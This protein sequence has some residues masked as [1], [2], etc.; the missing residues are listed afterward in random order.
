MPANARSVR[1]FAPAKVNLLLHVGDRRADG[2]HDLQS[3]VAFAS[4]GDEL[5]LEQS[6][7]LSLAIEGAFASSLASDETNL[8]LRAARAL[9]ATTANRGH[10]HIVL[11][12]NLPVASGIGGGS[13]D[14]AATLRGLV[15]LWQLDID[16]SAL[17]RIAED[18]GSDVPVCMSS[19]PSWMEGRGERV[20]ELPPLPALSLVL[21]NPGIAISTGAVFDALTRRRGIEGTMPT[22]FSNPDTL[23]EFLRV[24]S[25]DLE[26]AALSIAPVIGDVLKAL[27][28]TRNIELARMSGSGATCFGLFRSERDAVAAASSLR[29]A[30]R[31]WWVQEA[32]FYAIGTDQ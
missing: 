4:V 5:R 1:A 21:V 28:G 18:L 26:P 24:T 15:H 3:L 27:A 23:L 16:R 25:N 14:A 8:A 11:R 30:R 13:A 32:S 17:L 6:E 31:D 29:Q 19:M 2:Y 7:S 22:V 9:S 12:K 20:T 10:V